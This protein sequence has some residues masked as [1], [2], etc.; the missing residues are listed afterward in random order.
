MRKGYSVPRDFTW[1]ENYKLFLRAR[2]LWRRGGFHK[3][4]LFLFFQMKQTKASKQILAQMKYRLKL[5]KKTTEKYKLLY[6]KLLTSISFETYTYFSLCLFYL[7]LKEE[8]K[9]VAETGKHFRLKSSISLLLAII[10]CFWEGDGTP[11]YWVRE[12]F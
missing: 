10:E 12:C 9:A 6:C 7:N 1:I 8:P 11:A 4:Q 5:A 2:C 3:F